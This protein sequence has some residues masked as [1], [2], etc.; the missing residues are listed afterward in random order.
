MSKSMYAKL[1]SYLIVF[2][3]C[4]LYKNI[5]VYIIFGSIQKDKITGCNTVLTELG[6]S[7]RTLGY[8]TKFDPI[9]S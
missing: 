6:F 5:L 2:K 4:L 8:C 3:L 7:L 1:A 9:H